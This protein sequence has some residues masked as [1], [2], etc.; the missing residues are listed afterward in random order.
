MDFY[1][2]LGVDISQYV[3][4][5]DGVAAWLEDILVYV[6][7]VDVYRLLAVEAFGQR[8][9]F[10][11]VA[12]LVVFLLEERHV[13]APAFRGFLFLLFPFPVELVDV[14]LA[15]NKGFVAECLQQLLMFLHS[16]E[17]TECTHGGEG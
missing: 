5:G 9:E 17:R 8:E 4:A 16:V 10:H 7:V 12:W 2:V 15:K 13:S 11:V 6:L 14:L 1:A 3:I